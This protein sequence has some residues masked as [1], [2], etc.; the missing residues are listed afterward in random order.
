MSSLWRASSTGIEA[1]SRSGRQVGNSGLRGGGG[2][3]YKTGVAR[4]FL[5]MA[6]LLLA[7]SVALRA[8][9]ILQEL[10]SGQKASLQKGAQ[11]MVTEEV[12]GKPWPRVRIYQIV[13]ATP[14]EVMAVFID[15]N[16][17]KTFVPNILKSEITKE[18]SPT[19]VEIDYGLDIPIFPDEFYT[20]R[21]VIR[22]KSG[23]AF[24][25][26]WK[27][28]RAVQTKDIVG[29]FRAEPYDGKSL[30]CYQNLVTPGSGM[31]GLLKKTAIGQ[32]K[33]A[34]TAIVGEIERK[35]QKEPQ[36]VAAQV[37]ALQ[38]ALH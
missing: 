28:V 5:L 1:F 3:V 8:D 33:Q 37:K 36:A 32:M 24:E 30:V 14:E 29:S 25:V 27:L 20:T 9:T 13:N 2:L 38:A 7:V 15:Y 31:A 11:V 10:D 17:A 4:T 16:R 19:E 12:E 35:T 26:S 18:I 23:G 6:S 34:E 21:N 22:A